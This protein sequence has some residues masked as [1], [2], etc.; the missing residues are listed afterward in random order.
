MDRIIS[1]Y[2]SLETKQ[3]GEWKMQLKIFLR[4]KGSFTIQGNDLQNFDRGWQKTTSIVE[5]QNGIGIDRLFK[6]EE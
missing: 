5:S 1:G 2:Q 3:D 6:M 4:G